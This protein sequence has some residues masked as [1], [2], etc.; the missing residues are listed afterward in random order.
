MGQTERRREGGTEGR[1]GGINHITGEC[2]KAN[3]TCCI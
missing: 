3:K 2:S 1:E